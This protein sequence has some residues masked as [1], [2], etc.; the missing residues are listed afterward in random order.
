MRTLGSPCRKHHLPQLTNKVLNQ[1][2][3]AG[4]E[5]KNFMQGSFIA[6]F[7]KKL[8]CVC[9][10]ALSCECPWFPRQARGMQS[11]GEK[12]K[13]G[14]AG[15]SLPRSRNAPRPPFSL[16]CQSSG[17]SLLPVP[18]TK[19]PLASTPDFGW[20]TTKTLISPGSG[21]TSSFLQ[22][23]K[24]DVGLIWGFWYL[25]GPDDYHLNGQP[26]G[27]EPNLVAERWARP[28]IGKEGISLCLAL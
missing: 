1:N 9:P 8:S 7:L 14:T 22:N 28:A 13:P 6:Q 12:T 3:S 23:W 16:F 27:L 20:S 19:A 25:Q 26:Q 4:R 18:H 15:A 10:A 5:V 21:K 11:D 24:G 2:A 17:M